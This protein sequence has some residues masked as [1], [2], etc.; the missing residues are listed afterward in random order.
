MMRHYAILDQA[1]DG[2]APLPGS[3]PVTDDQHAAANAAA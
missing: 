1:P 2:E 3:K